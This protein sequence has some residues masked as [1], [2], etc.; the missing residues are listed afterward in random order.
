MQWGPSGIR[1][2]LSARYVSCTSHADDRNAVTGLP[3]VYSFHKTVKHSVPSVTE[4]WSDTRY[5]YAT[6]YT[7]HSC[8]RSLDLLLQ[9]LL[10]MSVRP[11]TVA[12]NPS[13]SI[14]RYIQAG[15]S[16]SSPPRPLF[17]LGS[18]SCTLHCNLSMA[19]AV[20]NCECLEGP[21]TLPSCSCIG[22][23][24]QF[25]LGVLVS[26]H[27]QSLHGSRAAI[28]S[29]PIYK[30]DSRRWYPHLPRPRSQFHG[31]QTA[32]RQSWSRTGQS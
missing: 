2:A 27:S 1:T 32:Q 3:I 19:R 15:A 31:I 6:F 20:G 8:P 24:R 29:V 13:H 9:A 30:E 28:S 22:I 17:G 12:L 11:G 10:L 23:Y 25:L 21:G 18:G 4:P 26:S 7:A 14:Y 16:H 5:I